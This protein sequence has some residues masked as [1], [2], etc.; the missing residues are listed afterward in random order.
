VQVRITLHTGDSS[1]PGKLTDEHPAATPE[2]PLLVL[3]D[4]PSIALGPLV[5]S[6]DHL[7]VVHGGKGDVWDLVHAAVE[8]GFT[9]TWEGEEAD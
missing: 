8:T 5:L 3:D 2:Q 1:R 6:A 4:R 9:V 7:I